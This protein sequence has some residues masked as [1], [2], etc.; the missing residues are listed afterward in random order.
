MALSL[1]Q[2]LSEIVTKLYPLGLRENEIWRRAGG[3]LALVNLSTNGKAQWIQALILIENGGGGE[4]NFTSLISEM[5][6]DFVQNK[7]LME[8]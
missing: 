8:L 4:I 1:R 5:R 7:S 3:D 2:R 6:K